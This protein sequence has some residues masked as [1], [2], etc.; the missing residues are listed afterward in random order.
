VKEIMYQKDIHIL[1]REIAIERPYEHLKL[2]LKYNAWVFERGFS[3]GSWLKVKSKNENKFAVKRFILYERKKDYEEER[4]DW[5][6][7]LHLKYGGVEVK[8]LRDSLYP[9]KRE[10]EENI[11]Y[12]RVQNGLVGDFVY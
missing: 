2:A 4:K 12:I 10:Y 6:N 9:T 3:Y 7:L 5:F 8:T 1:K 11:N